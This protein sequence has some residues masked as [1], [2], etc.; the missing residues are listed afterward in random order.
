MAPPVAPARC[1]ASTARLGARVGVE[2]GAVY[3]FFRSRRDA[4]R[5][6]MGVREL[7]GPV[8]GASAHGAS[9]VGVGVAAGAEAAFVLG[10]AF[11]SGRSR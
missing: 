2:G 9:G 7:G 3:E 10:A 11:G 1:C 5:N 6:G 8:W 4:R